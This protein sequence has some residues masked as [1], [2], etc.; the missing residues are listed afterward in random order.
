MRK[1]ILIPCIV[2]LFLTNCSD[3]IT[4]PEPEPGRRDYLWTIDTLFSFNP[5]YRLWGSSPTDVWALS[6]GTL[7]EDIYHYNGTVWSTDGVFRLLS[8][9][10]IW[11]FSKN[12]IYIGGSNGS[13]WYYD[14]NQWNETIKLTKDGHTDI[15]FDNMWGNSP[16]NLYATGAY[17]DN[18]GLANNSVIAHYTGN[19]WE[20]IETD[21][22]V[23]IV[24][25]LFESNK[26][27]CVYLQ[28][29]KYSNSYDSTYIYE[30]NNDRYKLIYSTIWSD[31]WASISLVNNEVYFILNKKIAIRKNKQFETVL[32]LNTYNFDQIIY[33]RNSKDIFISMKDGLAH[34]NGTNIVY[35]FYFDKPNT[36]IFRGTIFNDEIFFLVYE[37]STNLS[38][39]YHGKLNNGG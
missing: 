11:G 28:V 18:Y 27:Q 33:G 12:D 34:Y 1:R 17:H 8:P 4:D 30:Y 39:I 38:L 5:I 26:D 14:G 20:M 10:S 7:R 22:I 35:L 19:S 23:G 21:S 37:Y 32:D 29:I 13:I 31:T 36:H 9:Y 6:R 24:A 3:N 2:L 16:N 25:R 15:V